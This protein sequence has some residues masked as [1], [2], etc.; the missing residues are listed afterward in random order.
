[1]VVNGSED[2]LDLLRL[3]FTQAGLTP[4]TLHS[5]D[6]REGRV[7]FE[8]FVREH[9]PQVIVYDISFP[10]ELHWQTFNDMRS[11]AVIRDIPIVLTTTNVARLRSITGTDTAIEIV[12]KPS[13]LSVLLRAVCDAARIP[14]RQ[15]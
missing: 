6:L 9:Q 4:V 11:R 10:Y 14:Q 7:D 3:A 13:E 8:Q 15:I 1:M 12:D 5:R 2:T